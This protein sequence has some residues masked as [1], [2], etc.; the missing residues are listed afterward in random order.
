MQ[1]NE[2]LNDKKRRK[3]VRHDAD[4]KRNSIRDSRVKGKAH[5][6]YRGKNIAAKTL[7]PLYC[8]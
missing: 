3:G 7:G 4:Y 6:N 8:R 1:H 2:A 5:K